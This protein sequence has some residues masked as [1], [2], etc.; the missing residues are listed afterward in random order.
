MSRLPSDGQAERRKPPDGVIVGRLTPLR[1]PNHLTSNSHTPPDAPAAS[2]LPF[3]SNVRFTTN[4][5][6]QTITRGGASLARSYRYTLGC[7]KSSGSGS[8]IRAISSF[9]VTAT[10]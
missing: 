1:L 9:L 10:T 5:C 4:P 7:G 8:R 6:G 3:G 2:H